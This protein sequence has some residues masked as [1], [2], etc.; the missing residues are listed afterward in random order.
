MAA[1]SSF[2]WP[3]LIARWLATAFVV[4]ATYNPSGHSYFHWLTDTADGRWSLKALAGLSLIIA[5]LTFFYATLRAIGVTGILS[6]LTFF[7][8]VIWAMVDNGLLESL[9]AWAW[10]TIVLVVVASILAIGVSWSHVRSRLSGQT[11]SNDVTL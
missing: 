5:L 7:S 3:N 10:V 6:A 2:S 11:D 9:G 1:P 4:F 8:V